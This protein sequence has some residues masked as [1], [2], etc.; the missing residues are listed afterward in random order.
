MRE[1]GQY[2]VELLLAAI[3]Q[4]EAPLERVK[5]PAELVLRRTSGA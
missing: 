1:M 3:D 4:P 2:G 5:L